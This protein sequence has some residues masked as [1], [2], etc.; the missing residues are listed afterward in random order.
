MPPSAERPFRPEHPQTLP[1]FSVP[2]EAFTGDEARKVFLIDLQRLCRTNDW[3]PQVAEAA[4]ADFEQLMAT[5]KPGEPILTFSRHYGGLK[6]IEGGIALSEP[7]VLPGMHSMEVHV[8]MW[9]I[10]YLES[11]KVYNTNKSASYFLRDRQAPAHGTVFM[12][13]EEAVRE[14]TRSMGDRLGDPDLTPKQIKAY[15]E[16]LDDFR[17]TTLPFDYFDMADDVRYNLANSI[18]EHL[19]TRAHGYELIDDVRAF[20]YVA[21]ITEPAQ[22]AALYELLEEQW[23]SLLELHPD[24]ERV[25]VVGRIAEYSKLRAPSE[26]ADDFSV[27][28]TAREELNKEIA[29]FSTIADLYARRADQE[30][31]AGPRSE[32]VVL[33]RIE[34]AEPPEPR[35]LTIFTAWKNENTIAADVRYL[36]EVREAGYPVD[37]ALERNEDSMYRGIAA[38]VEYSLTD[39]DAAHRLEVF[40]AMEYLFDLEREEQRDELYRLLCKRYAI[41]IPIEGRHPIKGYIHVAEAIGTLMPHPPEAKDGTP[42]EGSARTAALLSLMYRNRARQLMAKYIPTDEQEEG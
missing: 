22:Y 38:L 8:P 18:M 42:Y 35:D 19:I 40:A 29:H 16:Y 41:K 28:T 32:Q 21:D 27:V 4:A 13:G 11:H 30:Q 1:E 24:D 36:R 10:S 39:I 17:R 12:A 6:L 7:F 5:V 3:P 23:A 9:H 25:G 15:I 2:S 34:L 33:P 31:A 20:A 14:Y 26:N 37:F